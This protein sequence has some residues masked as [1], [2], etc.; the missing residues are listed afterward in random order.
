MSDDSKINSRNGSAQLANVNSDL[1]NNF[2]GI[3]EDKFQDPFWRSSDDFVDYLRWNQV[4]PYQLLILKKTDNG[5]KDVAT[6]TLPIPPSELS[7]DVPYAISTIATLGGIVE[8]H[9][10]APIRNISFSGTTGM[11]PLA[12]AV[13]NNNTGGPS[14]FAGTVSATKNTISAVTSVNKPANLWEESDFEEQGAFGK[15]TGWFQFRLLSM[16][17]QRYVTI[18]KHAEGADYRLAFAMWKDQAVYLVTPVQFSLRRSAQSP[19]EYPYSVQFRAW[20]KIQLNTGIPNVTYSPAA[21]DHNKLSAI[22]TDIQNARKVLH[23]AVGVLQSIRT[24]IST[25]LLN[26]LREAALFLKDAVGAATS[27]AEFPA[28]LIRDCRPAVVTA[29][30]VKTVAENLPQDIR[31]EYKS[32]IASLKSAAVTT[33]KQSYQNASPAAPNKDFNRVV[34]SRASLTGLTPKPPDTIVNGPDPAWKIFD[35]TDRYLGL[36]GALKPSDLNLPASANRAINTEKDR[37]RLFTRKDFETKRDSILRVMTDYADAVGLGDARYSAFY[38]TASSQSIST[39]TATD[40]DYDILFTLNQTVLQFNKLAASGNINQDIVDTVQYISGLASQSGIAFT[41][42]TSKYLIPF[43]YGYTLEMLADRYL[44][45]PDR[46]LEIATLNGLRA[47]YIDETGFSVTLLT[48][49]HDNQVTVADVSNLYVGQSVY[50]ASTSVRRTVRRITGINKIALNHY[51]IDVDGDSNLDQYTTLSGASI[52]TFL[53][54]TVNSQKTIYM[55]SSDPSA[56]DNFRSKSI[57]NVNYFDDMVRVGGVD[58]LLSN[59]NDLIFTE[60]GDTKLAVGYANLVQAVKLAISTR[61]GSVIRHPNYGLGV[62]IGESTANVSARDLLIAA[63][64]LLSDDNRFKGVKNVSVVKDGK[65]LTISMG[66]EVA[67][68]NQFL[69]ITLDIKK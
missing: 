12:G 33:Q 23:R 65:A 45:T 14:I 18:K 69:P 57:P 63:K 2:G 32:A 47:P 38:G 53:P 62:P 36:F 59:S 17:L 27:M 19:H 9:N 64:G 1:I 42:P 7:I 16:F 41:V 48:N 25:A 55:P 49:G 29:M 54:D 24:D 44:G 13:S 22:L 43:P 46:W 3:S 11:K 61:Q 28:E 31:T 35:N 40:D 52:Q 30:G 51:V 58:F 6:F 15:N 21:M 20:K 8:E 68:V 5:Y 34:N 4:Y 56:E 39:R 26:P 67:G 37:V 10:G 50:I 66:V 60:D